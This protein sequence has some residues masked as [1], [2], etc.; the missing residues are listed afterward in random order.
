MSVFFDMDKKKSAKEVLEKDRPKSHSIMHDFNESGSSNASLFSVKV[1]IILL[2]AAVLGIGTGFVLAGG[3]SSKPISGE[4]IKSASQVQKGQKYGDD[5]T[6][7]FK[8]SAE[9]TLKKGGLDGEGEYHLERPG[10]ES[11]NV[12]VTSSTVD[13]SL[14][15]D[16]KIKVRGQTFEGQKAGWLM[17]VGQVEVIE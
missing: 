4:N 9:G 16:R 13:L 10:G 15:V 8:D 12:Y 17:D 14:F 7:A 3:G 2:V 6:N 5:N 11:Q 1:I